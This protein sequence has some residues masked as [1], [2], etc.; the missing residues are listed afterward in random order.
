MEMVLFT[1]KIVGIVIL[2][3]AVFYMLMIMPHL[4]RRPEAKSFKKWLYAHRGLHDNGTDA[5]EN[6]MAA[7]AKA[8]EA[9]FGI[10]LDIQLSKDRIP[11]V[12]HDFNLKRVCGVD[13]RV[14]DFTYEELRQFCLLESQE[15]I[16]RLEDVLKLVNGRVP[17]IVEFKIEFID[18]SLCSIA[19]GILR[20]YNGPY[21]MESFNPLGVWWYRRHHREV[22]RGQLSDAFLKKGE[23]RGILYF[24]LQNLLANFIGKPDFV[25]YD[26]KYPGVLSRKICR[27]LYRNT[28]AAWT[29]KSQEDLDRARRYFDIFI[30]ESFLPQ[31]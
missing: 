5:P 30:F 12:F 7:F 15:R 13:G 8:V 10:E 6:S 23:Y 11:V 28:A 4:R 3:L 19:D 25:A 1:L 20:R 29:I 16:P 2:L 18:L 9:G 31:T 27:D 17:L 21:C 14:K 24:M 22:M 26:H